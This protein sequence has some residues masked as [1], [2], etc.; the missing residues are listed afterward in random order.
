MKYVRRYCR[1]GLILI[2]LC[3]G[4][5]SVQAQTE[6]AFE[7]V[8]PA[9]YRVDEPIQQ[10]FSVAELPISSIG[11][12]TIAALNVQVSPSAAARVES[13]L[14]VRDLDH[15]VPIRHGRLYTKA[16]NNYSAL[17]PIYVVHRVRNW[18]GS[19]PPVFI[20]VQLNVWWQESR[21]EL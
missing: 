10:R 12:S 18:D 8:S 13:H 16:F 5:S 3:L 1:S 17:D 20:T 19:Y 11:T 7:Q 6:W 4:L 14:C 2:M 15:C 9:I 21:G